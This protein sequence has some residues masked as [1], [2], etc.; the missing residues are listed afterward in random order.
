MNRHKKRLKNTQSHQN[1][2]K[3]DGLNIMTY[4]VPLIQ[5]R[6]AFW[7]TGKNAVTVIYGKCV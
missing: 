6:Q 5:K 1:G 4:R 2:Q 3:A 7:Q